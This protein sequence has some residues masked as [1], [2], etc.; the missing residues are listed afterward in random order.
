MKTYKG[1]DKDLKCRGFQYEIGKE[2]ETDCAKVCEAGFHACKQPIDVFRYYPPA[3]SRFCEVMQS[4]DISESQ[5]DSKIASTKIKILQEIGIKEIINAQKEY[6]KNNC[7][8]IKEEESTAGYRGVSTAGDHGVSTAGYCGVST[9]GDFGVSTAGD[10]GVSRRIYSR[11]VRRIYRR[12]SRRIYSRRLRDSC[13]R[14]K[15]FRWGIWGW[16]S[17]W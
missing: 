17:S 7:K 1:F 4:G 6:V 14:R 11:R 10:H 12:R 13:E 9:A 8:I 3:K 15:C 16:V 2:Y 5:G